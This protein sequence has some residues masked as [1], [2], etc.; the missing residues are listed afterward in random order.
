MENT[1]EQWDQAAQSYADFHST[2]PYALFCKE[3]IRN[4][5]K[6]VRNLTVLDAGCGDGDY[7][8]I[9]AQNGGIVTGC[10]GSAEMLKIAKAT[11]PKYRFDMADLLGELPYTNDSFDIVL[12]NLVLMDIDPIDNAIHEFHRVLKKGGL[13]LF[14]IV[15]PAF[16]P[17]EW[18][19][20]EQGKAMCKKIFGYIT[21]QTLP[22][23][24]L[25]QNLTTHYHRTVSYYFNH[26]AQAGLAFKEMF[27]P[28]VYKEPKSHDLPLYLF[29]EFAK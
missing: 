21:H 13:F 17:G 16:Y 24:W 6:N 26:M 19:F 22:T 27:E 2:S 4:Q 5:F 25:G 10:D 12:C 11:Y 20:D 28:S 1:I 23:V 3:F 14:S 15:H 8:H 29:A 18:E 7:V 9:L